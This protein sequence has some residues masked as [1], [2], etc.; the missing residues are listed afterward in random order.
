MLLYKD[1]ELGKSLMCSSNRKQAS[2]PGPRP[3]RGKRGEDGKVAGSH[4]LWVG[5][6]KCFE[7]AVG[8]IKREE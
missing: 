6:L 1:L 7:E 3:V 8:E 2:A 4:I 5:H